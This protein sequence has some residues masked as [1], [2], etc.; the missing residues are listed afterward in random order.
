MKLIKSIAVFL[1]MIIFEV[2]L[3]VFA[4]PYW[5]GYLVDHRIER[6]AEAFLSW[7]EVEHAHTSPTESYVVEDKTPEPTEPEKHT[8]LWR[9]M[10]A[11]NRQIS[12]P[13]PA[14]RGRRSSSYRRWSL[15]HGQ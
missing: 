6:N 15:L 13:E 14:D 9:D 8:Q 5:H 10:M 4:Y 2:G 1:T 11:Y 12:V 3:A 7:V